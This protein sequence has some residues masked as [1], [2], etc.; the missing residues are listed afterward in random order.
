LANRK[1]PEVSFFDEG[2]EPTRVESR[3]PRPRRRGGAPREP[4][5]VRGPDR[6]TLLVRQGIA[7]GVGL[8]LIILIVLGVKGC[9]DSAKENALK[10]Y[11]RDVTAVV[12]DS[13]RDVGRAFFQLLNGGAQQASDL[14][15]QV[16]ELRLAADEDLNRA[17]AFD[18][19]DEMVP[20]QRNLELTL[21]LRAE[22][23]RKIAEALPTALGRGQPAER[24]IESIAGEMQAF[25]ASDVVYDTRVAP[26]IKQTLDEEGISGQRIADSQFMTD[27]SWLSPETVANRL[28]AESGQQSTEVAPGTHGHGL[29]GVSVGDVTLQPSPAVNRVPVSGGG[30]TFTVSFENQGEND[31]RSV[32]VTVTLRG[33]SRPITA[34]R[35]VSQTT[36][37]SPAEVEIPLGAT[38]PIGQAVTAEVVV[39]AVRGE[40]KTDNNRQRYTI[41][42]T[43]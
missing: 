1:E 16:N 33:G 5:P 3:T 32:R 28:G 42:F 14:Q 2:D 36:A 26:L 17:K 18:V 7:V 12:T 21:S 31:E 35:T 9:T 37:G 11:N 30:V 19:P 41:I 13:D 27:I 20:A 4:R 39:A 10:D 23:L 40:E 6:R 24:A 34:R 22:G 29:S 43:R 38:P 15:V 8:L 25:L